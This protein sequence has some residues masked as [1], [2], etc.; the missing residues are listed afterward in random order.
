MVYTLFAISFCE[1]FKVFH[2]EMKS[3]IFAV[4]VSIFAQQAA[5]KKRQTV[6]STHLSLT[7]ECGPAVQDSPIVED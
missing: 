4:K 2:L 7:A 5:I 3:S 1:K 6:A